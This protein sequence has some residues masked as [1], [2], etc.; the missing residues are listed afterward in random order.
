MNGTAELH[1]V[2]RTAAETGTLP[3]W[4]VMTEARAQHVER[5]TALLGEWA[6]ELGLS[7]TDR[8]RWS[9]AARLHDA[10]K[11]A[12]LTEL[13]R[14]VADA[15]RWPN[16]V[17]HGPACAA[18]LRE[19]GVGDESVLA[20]ITYHP[21]GHPDLD[22]LGRFLYLADYLE[23]GRAHDPEGRA[24][25]RARLPGERDAVLIEVARQRIGH[26]ISERLP[27][28]RWTLEFWNGLVG[29]G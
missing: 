9:A 5:V 17:L 20:A 23:P 28:L 22:D 29:G 24:A 8:L 3:A 14:L 25:L 16:N 19:D 10:M 6:V 7:P 12:E 26:L 1:P 11:G 15:D 13:R 4:A 18:R 27:I 21:T 2:L